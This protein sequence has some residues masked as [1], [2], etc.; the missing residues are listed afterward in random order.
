MI[1]GKVGRS[2]PRK[3]NGRR[4]IRHDSAIFGVIDRERYLFPAQIDQIDLEF[5]I[6]NLVRTVFRPKDEAIC[7]F[8][9]DQP[10][11]SAA[12]LKPIIT[13]TTLE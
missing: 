4:A 8:A 1:L 7:A 5:E 3:K 12:A 2:Y 13:C 10:V 11:V 6:A 9:A